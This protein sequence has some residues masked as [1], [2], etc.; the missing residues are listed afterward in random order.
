[1]TQTALLHVLAA[2]F[3]SVAAVVRWLLPDVLGDTP[4]LA[5]YPAVVASAM[6]GG[7][8]PGVAATL[9][10]T[11]CYLLWFDPDPG[12]TFSREFVDWIRIAIFAAG[13]V[14][15]SFLARRQQLARARERRQAEEV[16]EQAS[17]RQAVMANMG[18]GLFTVDSQGLITYMNPAA[19]RAV[20]WTFSELAGRRI[21]D[22]NHYK[23]PEGMPYPI[24]ECAWRRALYQG[25]ILTNHEDTFIRRDGSFLPVVLS[26]APLGRD[27]AAGLVIVFRDVSRQKQAEEELREINRT[28]EQRVEERTAELERR[29]EE[30]RALAAELARTEQ[31]EQRRLAQWLH[32][33]LQQLLV[34]TKMQIA[35][36]LSAVQER[37]LRQLLEKACRLIDE[38]IGQSRSLTTELTPPILYQSGLV[39]GLEQLAHWV[40]EK[41]RLDVAVETTTD[42]SPENQEAAVVLFSA[43]RE[44]LFNVVKHSGVHQAR[45][46]LSQKE[47]RVQLAVEDQG[48]GFDLAVLRDG[49]KAGFGLLNIRERLRS[50]GGDVQ[51]RSEPGQGTCV[52]L[53]APAAPDA[54][55]T[56]S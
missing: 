18:E 33:D 3:V 29:A 31:R 44:L 32:D 40:K 6:L 42:V 46:T 24:E 12:T 26:S 21:H 56:P 28:L 11:L 27:K 34:A 35:L 9:G 10:A 2:A 50:I 16:M 7:F 37:G 48:V 43:A 39:P 55:A 53:I 52:T 45:V 8:G 22:A 20:G 54:G 49:T 14:G 1:M 30:L 13:G 4:F 36:T 51:F 5:F 41:H 17:F 25:A 15:V 23:H 19:E 47:G 38:S